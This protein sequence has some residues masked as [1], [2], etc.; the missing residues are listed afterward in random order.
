MLRS[1]L[2]QTGPPGVDEP[3]AKQQLPGPR[4]ASKRV[5]IDYA[6][7]SDHEKPITGCMTD[8]V[9]W[10]TGP[11]RTSKKWV[12]NSRNTSLCVLKYFT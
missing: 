12:E 5:A 3:R 11:T 6:D 1:P 7:E 10:S 9:W 4:L 8:E 2:Y